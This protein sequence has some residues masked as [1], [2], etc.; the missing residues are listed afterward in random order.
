MIDIPGCRERTNFKYVIN[1]QQKGS[2]S[3]P[4]NTIQ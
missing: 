3:K 1:M 4:F 2:V